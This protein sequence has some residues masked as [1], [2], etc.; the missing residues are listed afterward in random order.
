MSDCDVSCELY[1]I[2]T[3]QLSESMSATGLSHNIIVYAYTIICSYLS[4]LLARTTSSPMAFPVRL[5]GG[6]RFEGRVEVYYNG[7]W[8]T[9]CDDGWDIVDAK[10]VA[11]N[12]M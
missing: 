5:N 12:R 6:S 8:G 2:S 4:M 3:Q 9:V 10:Y 7:E 11:A 1:C